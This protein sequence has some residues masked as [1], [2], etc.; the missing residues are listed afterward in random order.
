MA[1]GSAF[2]V[3]F[4][5]WTFTGASSRA[6][7]DGWPIMVIFVANAFGFFCNA[8]YFGPKLRQLRVITAMEGVKQR[9]GR[10]SEQ[11]FTSAND[12]R[13]DLAL[14]DGSLFLGRVRVRCS[15]YDHYYRIVRITHVTPRWQLGSDRE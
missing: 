9:F 6:Y 14:W 3:S 1:G 10:H 15:D 2:M 7:L 4:S 5:A 12:D 8:V 11:V 13:W